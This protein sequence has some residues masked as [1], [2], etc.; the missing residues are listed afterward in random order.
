[1]SVTIYYSAATG[2]RE[3][4][5]QQSEIF[6]YLDAK[7][8]KYFVKDITQSPEIKTEM[9]TKVGNPSAMPP[10]IFN[11]DKYC[12]DYQAFFNA[13]EEEKAEKFFKL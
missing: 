3:V 12:G 5:Q 13:V 8:I 4:K 9:R 2:S 11:G 6:Q 1:M 7:K 10:Q